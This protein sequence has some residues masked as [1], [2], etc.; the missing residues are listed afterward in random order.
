LFSFSTRTA[1]MST[2]SWRRFYCLHR[3]AYLYD[4][5]VYI[6]IYIYACMYI[7]VYEH[8]DN[9]L[10]F[11]QHSCAAD[12]YN[13]LHICVCACLLS[14][15]V[16]HTHTYM[17]IY[18]YIYVYVYAYIYIGIYVY[19]YIHIYIHIHIHIHRMSTTS[20]RR[21]SSLHR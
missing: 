21:S 10:V 5:C 13:E 3:F 14:P 17:Y 18:I 11:I 15:Q 9:N 1:R 7:C 12:E 8:I 16:T 4:I 2:M 19:T 20:W 6:Y